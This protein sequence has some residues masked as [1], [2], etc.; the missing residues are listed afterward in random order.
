MKF[1]WD[2]W[3]FVKEYLIKVIVLW[4]VLFSAFS[5]LVFLLTEF[6]F[7]KEIWITIWIW[8]VVIGIF[9]AQVVIY[10]RV[11]RRQIPGDKIEQALK[12]VADLRQEGVNQLLN[13]DANTI[14][15]E[16]EL[17]DF[18]EK[19]EN[20][21][22]RLISK[23]EK[24]SPAQGANFGEIGRLFGMKSAGCSGKPATPWAAPD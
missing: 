7:G 14:Q 13:V 24:V 12:E 16:K 4:V 22:K 10:Y 19:V 5:A 15:K 8:I 17:Q 2:F 18:N 11:A 20:W 6:G 3:D 23:I 9:L 21:K 1:N